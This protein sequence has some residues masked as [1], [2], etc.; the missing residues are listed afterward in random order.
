MVGVNMV[1]K[2]R[3]LATH[4]VCLFTFR[5]RRVGSI[6]VASARHWKHWEFIT[7]GRSGRGEQWMGVVVYNKLVYQ[8]IQITTPCFH[9]T[10]LYWILNH[11]LW[12]S[13]KLS[14]VY[15]TVEHTVDK[16]ALEYE[17][18]VPLFL[19]DPTGA[20]GRKQFFTKSYGR[21]CLFLQKSPKVSGNLREFTGECN[22]GIRYSS[23]LLVKWNAAGVRGGKKPFCEP[24]PC[25]PAAETAPRPPIW[26]F[27][28]IYI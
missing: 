2:T 19:R 13:V 21:L 27:T 26:C 23:S 8:I 4:R 6:G 28:Y 16:R 14:K 22:L 17:V 20:N 7:G 5:R 25:N 3:E 15:R 18:R 1:L 11:M 9:C 12:D 10:H 24:L